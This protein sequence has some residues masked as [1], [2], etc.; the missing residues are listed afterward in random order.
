MGMDE[1]PG[2]ETLYEF[3]DSELSSDREVEILRHL[4]SCD[5]CL[6]EV[7]RMRRGMDAIDASLR[8]LECP[9]DSDE[10]DVK[11]AERQVLGQMIREGVISREPFDLRK[12]MLRE[13]GEVARAT[14]KVVG[15]GV[16]VVR[17]LV[18]TTARAAPLAA[19][20]GGAAGKTLARGIGAVLR[21]ALMRLEVAF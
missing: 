18:A 7:A 12:V 20:V 21:P 1:C 6:A 8:V 4:S 11:A 13:A 2:E 10:V 3:L 9:P 19:R 5:C 14:R 17:P 16:E 15:K